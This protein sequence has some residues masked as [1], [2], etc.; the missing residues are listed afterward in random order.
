MCEVLRH[1][2]HC[3]QRQSV[4][5]GG[6]ASENGAVKGLPQGLVCTVS[7]SALVDWVVS[8][9]LHVIEQTSGHARTFA[10][11]FCVSGRFLDLSMR[12]ARTSPVSG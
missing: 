8:R 6:Y 10:L 4:A 3:F 5:V 9:V 7:P 2:L 11:K 1:C 12:N